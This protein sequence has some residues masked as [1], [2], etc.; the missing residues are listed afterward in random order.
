MA[1]RNLYG[2]NGWDVAGYFQCGDSINQVHV[3]AHQKGTANLTFGFTDLGDS[4]SSTSPRWRRGDTL[5][6]L[7]LT[8]SQRRGTTGYQALGTQDY[9]YF[10]WRGSIADSGLYNSSEVMM[11]WGT[12]ND[13]YIDAPG[14]GG[15]P[16]TLHGAIGVGITSNAADKIDVYLMEANNTTKKWTSLA[17]LGN[18]ITLSTSPWA[19]ET[20]WCIVVN[21]SG[22]TK[23]AELIYWN[24]SAWT[25]YG[26]SISGPQNCTNTTIS[27]LETPGFFGGTVHDPGG[28]SV[29]KSVVSARNAGGMW[30][31]EQDQ[32]W[33][34]LDDG[35][36]YTTTASPAH[37]EADNDV[38]SWRVMWRFPRADTIPNQWTPSGDCPSQGHYSTL[39]NIKRAAPPAPPS[40]Y[41]ESGNTGA[42]SEEEF[43]INTI[44]VGAKVKAVC[45]SGPVLSNGTAYP[46]NYFGPEYFKLQ[47][48]SGT[49]TAAPEMGSGSGIDATN[50]MAFFRFDSA[51]GHWSRSTVVAASFLVGFYNSASV[52]TNRKIWGLGVGFLATGMTQGDSSSVCPASFVP[53]VIVV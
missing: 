52:T 29:P 26:P 21:L 11:V 33:S 27:S 24:G 48:A 12:C 4:P 13:P 3:L 10:F 18:A 42:V 49:Q 23:T 6:G 22:A 32:P 17:L 47:D 36:H 46:T 14:G 50:A 39:D 43:S 30:A 34:T 53:K 44:D 16:R 8:A 9:Q 45:L 41:L 51:G 35:I 5:N 40:S 28:I 7:A 38:H 2:F 19:S 15:T 31:F 20:T 37:G 1:I 25:S